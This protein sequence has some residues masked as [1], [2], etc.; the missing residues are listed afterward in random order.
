MTEIDLVPTPLPG[1]ASGHDCSSHLE[2]LGSARGS[3][4]FADQTFAIQRCR[5]CGLGFTDPV[6][7]EDTAPLLYQSRGSADFQQAD[8]GLV[9]RMKAASARRDASAFIGPAGEPLTIVDY[10]CGNGAFVTALA[11]VRPGAR[12]VGTDLHATPP[13]G[14]EDGQYLPYDRIGE[15][16]GQVDLVLVRHVLEHTYDPLTFLRELGELLRPGGTLSIE[17]PSL[18]AAI[19][20]IWGKDWMGFYAPYH[21][22]HFAPRSLARVVEEAGYNVTRIA[23][24]EMPMM[25]RSLQSRRRQTGYGLVAF[26]LGLLMH[27]VQLALGAITGRPACVRL[28]ATT[29][30]RSSVGSGSVPASR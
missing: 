30:G 28:W 26:G 21:T 19:R 24:A 22:L 23:G 3:A 11:G 14:L 8:S 25:G 18:D 16:A 12:V 6:P 20:P 29:T 5:I 2:A 27:P 10:G 7:S 17:V 15:L 4:P 13:P 9:S 1:V